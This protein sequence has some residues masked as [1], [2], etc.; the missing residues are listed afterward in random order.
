[1]LKK[2]AAIYCIVFAIISFNIPSAYGDS[3]QIKFDPSVFNKKSLESTTEYKPTQ[4]Q[5]LVPRGLSNDSSLEVKQ[6][7]IIFNVEEEIS[8]LNGPKEMI[9][10][11]VMINDSESEANF[12][13]EIELAFGNELTYVE[14]G[15][16]TF[17][18]EAN[19]DQLKVLESLPSVQYIFKQPESDSEVY[20]SESLFESPWLQGKI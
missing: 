19:I 15:Y 14:A 1:M 4:L 5:Q 9:P 11:Q 7:K 13:K 20:I 10:I 16:K 2:Q 8:E 12:S 3:N 6:N 18:L 17:N